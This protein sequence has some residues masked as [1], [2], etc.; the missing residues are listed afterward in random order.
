MQIPQHRLQTATSSAQI[1][2]PEMTRVVLVSSA[3]AGALPAWAAE[4]LTVRILRDPLEIPFAILR[5]P[6]DIIVSDAILPAAVGTIELP[7]LLQ[8]S[9]PSD[10]ATARGMLMRV[11]AAAGATGAPLGRLAPGTADLLRDAQQVASSVRSLKVRPVDSL[12][13][14][15]ISVE[16]EAA[17]APEAAAPAEEKDVAGVDDLPITLPGRAPT[18]SISIVVAPVL[19]LTDIEELIDL[20]EVAPGLH[21]RFR[22]YRDGAYRIDGLAEDRQGLKGWLQSLSGV[23]AVDLDGD[24]ISVRMA[25]LP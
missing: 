24:H 19:R 17:N 4:G 13:D 14:P 1:R 18:E 3:P 8:Q 25:A 7:V 11:A 5:E 10:P 22:L 2:E 21:I 6:T 12:V 9:L 16:W 15:P 20:L 23:A